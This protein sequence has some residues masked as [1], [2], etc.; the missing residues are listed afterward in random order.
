MISTCTTSPI[1]TTS[2]GCLMRAYASSLLWIKT[3][4]AAEIDEGAEVGQA[5]DDALANLPDLE[6]VEQLLL[7]GLQL[8]FENEALRKHDAMALVI[9]IDHLQAQ[10]LADEFVEI[11][12]R[13]TAN[14]RRRHEAA[15]AEIDEHA[16]FDDLR[17]RRFDDF[18]A[19]VRLDD[20]LP[21][22]ERAGAALGEKER[23]VHL[24]DAMN[25]HFDGVADLASSLG[26]IASESSRNGRTPSDF[27][28][29]STSTSSLSFWTIV[30]VSTW[31]SSRTLSDSS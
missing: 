10:M 7:L 12:D 16:A 23:S 3:V 28:P 18:V 15:H 26:S 31:P 25:H 14:L 13:L 4:D 1:F 27:P 17:D 6:R 9:E 5:H 8:F 19:I 30:P 22:L 29:T 21:R 11:A 20:L 2:D 24:V